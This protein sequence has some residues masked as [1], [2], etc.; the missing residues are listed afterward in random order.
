M[1]K[2]ELS[3]SKNYVKDWTVAD[4]VREFLQNAIDQEASVPDNDMYFQYA[5]G[6]QTLLIG[7]KS[8]V[9][10]VNTL[11]L[12]T[13]SKVDDENSIGQFGEGYK[14]ASLVL[15][16]AGKDVTIYNYG[17][18]EVWKPRFVKSRR[19]GEDILT[20]FVD[21]KYIWEKTPNNDLII[22]IKGITPEEYKVIEENTLRLRSDLGDC[23][24]TDYGKILLDEAHS[25]RIYVNGLYVYSVPSLNYGYDVKPKY[26]TLGRDR[27]VVNTFDCQWLTSTIALDAFRLGYHSFVVDMVLN[28]YSD[29]KY[30]AS[31]PNGQY[32]ASYE[33]KLALKEKFLN[34]YGEDAIPVD[35]D[36]DYNFYKNCGNKPI[37]CNTLYA[38]LLRGIIEPKH[39]ETVR[40]STRL[41]K[42]LKNIE[43]RISTE[44][45][46]ELKSIIKVLRE[47][48]GKEDTED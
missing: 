34:E 17:N 22:S 21:T 41:A 3:L 38:S 40:L 27:N 44:D 37:I 9:L 2:Y 39:I 28:G 43:N 47:Q 36:E 5:E 8:S 14:I 10:N 4:A 29:V 19:Y 15:V 26:L 23:I 48:E 25:H 13:S 42:V 6:T 46:E 32:S 35:T 16:R 7:N 33:L 12:G 1:K 30:V 18:R 11:L 24:E 45:S 31:S 20:F